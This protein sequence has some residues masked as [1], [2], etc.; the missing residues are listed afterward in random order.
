MKKN[1][2]LKLV[3]LLLISLFIVSCSKDGVN[4]ENGINGKDGVNGQNGK[5]GQDGNSSLGKVVLFGDITDEE[6]KNIIASKVGENTHTI[7]IKNT[8][9]LTSVEFPSLDKIVDVEIQSNAKLTKVLFPKVK[10][11]Y[12]GLRIVDN[13]LLTTVSIPEIESTDEIYIFENKSLKSLSFSKLTRVFHRIDVYGNDSLESFDIPSISGKTN[14]IDITNNRNLSTIS[15]TNKEINSIDIRKNNKLATFSFPN[16]VVSDNITISSNSS[17]SE[18][19]F[20]NLEKISSYLDIGKNNKLLKVVLSKLVSVGYRL[21][22]DN[23]ILLSTINLSNLISLGDSENNSTPSIS[24]TENSSLTLLQLEKLERMISKKNDYV[25]VNI[26]E[27]NLEKIELPKFEGA[28]NGTFNTY[29]QSDNLKE[30]NLAS[31]KRLNNLNVNSKVGITQAS[32]DK[33][34]ATLVGITPAIKGSYITIDG[35]P[36]EQGKANAKKLSDAGNYITV[37][38]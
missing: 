20:N 28:T 14:R 21:S 1:Q 13:K 2:L 31:I 10:H 19:D 11:V 16:L 24:I 7:L 25:S 34:L 23:N 8:T 37:K 30:V 27:N 22:I 17:L 32:A 12:R 35:I 33:L 29:L 36:S 18:F 5:D 26:R 15:F 38:Q 6:A 4:G 9:N 3:T